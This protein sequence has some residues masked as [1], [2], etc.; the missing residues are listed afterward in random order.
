MTP[1]PGNPAATLMGGGWTYL[2]EV[3]LPPGDESSTL[4]VTCNVPG[5]APIEVCLLQQTS[6]TA[7][8]LAGDVLSQ[9]D[10]LGN[11]TTYTYDLQGNCLSQTDP[12]GKIT[13]YTYD[14]MGNMLM[15]TDPDNNKTTWTYD[16][17]GRVTSQQETVALGLNS[18]GTP[19]TTLATSYYSY[20]ANGNLVQ[21]IDA[22]GRVTKYAYDALDRETGEAWY[23]NLTDATHG[24][25]CQET[26]SYTYDAAGNLLTA[27][28]DCE[29]VGWDEPS[30]VPP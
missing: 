6:A 9:T 7:Y 20:D 11:T 23:P 8:D 13:N 4:T 19:Q 28:D 16:H 15:L 30:A 29:M 22:D 10:A 21:Q 26:L 2:G 18:A 3:T 27:I 12:N 1:S 25:N 5:T 17:L 14:A 24:W